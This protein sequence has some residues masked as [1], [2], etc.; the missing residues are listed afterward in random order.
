LAAQPIQLGHP[1]IQYHQIGLQSDGRVRSRPSIRDGSYHVEPG[2][3]STGSPEQHSEAFARKQDARASSH[4]AFQ[5]P[6]IEFQ[7]NSDI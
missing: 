5:F 1:N 3:Q 7:L 4:S 2:L 6:T